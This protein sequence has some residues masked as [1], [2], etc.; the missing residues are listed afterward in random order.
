MTDTGFTI[1]EIKRG[2]HKT[3]TGDYICIDCG[4]RFEADEIY[5]VEGRFFNSHAA[6]IKHVE[7]EHGERFTKLLETNQKQFRLTQR[8]RELL[9]HF[10]AGHTDK[11]IAKALGISTSTVRYQRFTFRERARAFKLYLAIWEMAEG[12]QQKKDNAD[13][14]DIHE[15]ATMVDERYMIT[16]DEYDRILKN[17]FLSMEPLKLLHFPVKEKKKL[18]ILKRI[19]DE[20]EPER[21]YTEKEVNAILRNIFEDY[22]TIRRYLIE[23]GFM[24]RTN[25]CAEYWRLG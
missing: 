4:E 20:F 9:E 19:I 5:P 2:W 1:E 22:V 6:V 7:R 25:D 17:A 14:M 8:Q 13:V 21:K 11:D 18:V 15:S 16:K 23:Y 3:D 10:H 12:G 24:D